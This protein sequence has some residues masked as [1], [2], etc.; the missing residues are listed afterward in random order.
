MFRSGNVIGGF[1]SAILSG[2]TL[3]G[4][5]YSAMI[6][7]YIEGN[8]IDLS[9]E[10]NKAMSI[11]NGSVMFAATIVLLALTLLSF[12]QNRVQALFL[13]NAC[14]GFLGIATKSMYIHDFGLLPGVLL[15]LFALW[16]MYSGL[17]MFIYLVQGEE[18][19]PYLGLVVE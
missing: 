1:A 14:L 19:F 4:N 9:V 7:L 10:N 6:E 8:G 15:F 17:G 2:I 11:A 18:L 16:E 5:A 13:S 3:V 12:K